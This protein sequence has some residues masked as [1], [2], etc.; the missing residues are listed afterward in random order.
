[1][2]RKTLVFCGHPAQILLVSPDRLFRNG[3]RAFDGTRSDVPANVS[4]FGVVLRAV[5]FA[6]THWDRLLLG[7]G[8]AGWRDHWPCI[9]IDLDNSA[10]RWAWFLSV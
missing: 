4:R 8:F 7:D 6:T 5:S 10:F 3:V 9:H 1:V 2:S